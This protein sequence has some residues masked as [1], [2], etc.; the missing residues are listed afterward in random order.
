MYFRIEVVHRSTAHVRSDVNLPN[1][2]KPELAP[3]NK[4]KC[5][6]MG[7]VNDQACFLGLLFSLTLLI[8]L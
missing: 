4:T 7:A 2:R 8:S 1:P 5:M 6:V 3:P